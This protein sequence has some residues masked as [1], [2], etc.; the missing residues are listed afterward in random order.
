MAFFS[1]LIPVYNQVGKMDKCIEALEAQRFRDFE[2]IIVDDG[3]TDASYEM[4]LGFA[5]KDS[6]I[7]VIRHEK[8]A[9]LVGA[10]YTGMQHAKGEY[11]LFIDSDDC[12]D[13]DAFEVLHKRLIETDPD[14]LWFGLRKEPSG[15]VV[16]PVETDDYLSDLFSGKI[17]PAVWKNVFKRS[18]TDKLIETT[19]PFYCNM[20]EDVYFSTVLFTFAKKIDTIDDVLYYYDCGT[21]MSSSVNTNVLTMEKFRKSLKD[22]IVAGEHILAFL[23][24]FGP[25]RIEKAKEKIRDMNKFVFLQHIAYEKDY[26]KIVEYAYEYKLMGLDDVYSEIC[27]V[28][29]K[30][31][32]LFDEGYYKI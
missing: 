11:V 2:V 7:S 13:A 3:S 26:C 24:R 23:E 1:I 27:N 22:T 30:R 14:V 5:E 16:T 31:K 17:Y 9:S 21:G 20:S 6:R 8:N 32:V 4:L 15:V 12:I 28:S 19:E 25:E 18:L 10:R 29:L